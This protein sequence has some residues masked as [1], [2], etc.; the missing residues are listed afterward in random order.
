MAM[1]VRKQE[2]QKSFY[3]RQLYRK[4]AV[5]DKLRGDLNEAKQDQKSWTTATYRSMWPGQTKKHLDFDMAQ[6]LGK[7]TTLLSNVRYMRDTSEAKLAAAAKARAHDEVRFEA[8]NKV[9]I[10]VFGLPINFVDGF[11]LF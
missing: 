11:F 6:Q 8:G 7:M 2:R 10:N 9:T 5:A 1:H 4:Q 3:K